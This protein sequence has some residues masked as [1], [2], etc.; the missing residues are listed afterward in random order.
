MDVISEQNIVIKRVYLGEKHGKDRGG[1]IIDIQITITVDG[2]LFY[3]CTSE[4]IG[5]KHA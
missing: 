4:Y 5:I 3:D 1:S 2:A